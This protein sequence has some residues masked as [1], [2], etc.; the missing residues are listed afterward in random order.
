MLREKYI[1]IGST[2]IRSGDKVHIRT[3]VKH[4]HLCAEN[5]GSGAAVANRSEPS[6]W[7]AF[8]ITRNR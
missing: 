5:G 3:F 8:I 2:T 1:L 6:A 7:E 4:Q